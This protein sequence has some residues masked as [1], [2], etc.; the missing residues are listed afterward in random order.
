MIGKPIFLKNWTNLEEIYQNIQ[1]SIQGVQRQTCKTDIQ[2]NKELAEKVSI[3]THNDYRLI[4]LINVLYSDVKNFEGG[5]LRHFCDHWKKYTSDT[6]ILDIIKDGLKLD[7]NEI[8]FQ[9]CCTNFPLSKKGM[10]LINTEIQKFKSKKVIVNT[11]KTT[12]IGFPVILPEETKMSATGWSQILKTFNKFIQ[13]IQDG[14]NTK[15]IKCD[16]KR[17]FCG[18]NWSKRCILLCTS[19]CASSKIS[20][21]FCKWVS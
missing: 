21:F 3:R 14:V 20:N 9:H 13:I 5:N 17:C 19:G 11:D 12:G 2:G 10:S 7:L 8:P 1:K 15:F 4:V 16:L 18:I 6:F